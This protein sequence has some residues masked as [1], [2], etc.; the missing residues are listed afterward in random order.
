[1]F[2]AWCDTWGKDVLVW[3]SSVE[4]IGNTDHG[5]VLDYRCA[6]G[7]HGQMLTG[8]ASLT[9]TARHVTP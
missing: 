1:M 3:P 5:I 9:T 6:C 8:T 2:R 7:H 4:D